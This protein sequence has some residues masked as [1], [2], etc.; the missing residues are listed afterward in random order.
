MQNK[1]TDTQTVTLMCKEENN[2]TQVTNN[3]Q[4][5]IKVFTIMD[6]L[7]LLNLAAVVKS[8]PYP[9]VGEGWEASST[10]LTSKSDTA[11]F[12]TNAFLHIQNKPFTQSIT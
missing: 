1:E 7:K 4:G 8:N 5:N 12:L 2:Q 9:V 10:S 3:K 11:I 6:E